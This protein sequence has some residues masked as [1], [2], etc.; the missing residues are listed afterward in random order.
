MT[1]KGTKTIETERLV[2]RQFVPEDAEAAYNNWCSDSSVTKYLTW[3]THAG[4]DVTKSLLERWIA[5][6]EKPD[7]YQWAIVPKELGQPIGSIS[8]VRMD[9]KTDQVEVGYCIGSK[10]WHRGIVSEAFAAVIR[11]LFTEVG[12]NRIQARHDPN[13]PHSGAVMKK[14]SLT[15]EGTLRQA[16]RNNTGLV[17][18]CMYSILRSEY[19][20]QNK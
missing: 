2:L 1:H 13:N 17:D 18:L 20:S 15:Y 7:W 3:P 14:C 6:Y 8:V 11:F 4:P 19:G 9:E 10:W 16:D 5:D 12:V